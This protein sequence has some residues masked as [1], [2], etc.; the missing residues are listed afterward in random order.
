MTR[1][2]LT[3]GRDWQRTRN[4]YHASRW[5]RKRC[6]WCRTRGKRDNPIELNHLTYRRGDRPRWWQVRPLCR[7]CHKIETNVTR[8]V[9][10]VLPWTGPVG[11][12]NAHYVVTYLGRWL[13]NATALAPLWLPAAY[14]WTHYR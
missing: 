11:K 12:R 6:F 5:T 1:T 13:V 4:R 14:L 10:V 8:V 2:E 7:R 3:Y 9:R